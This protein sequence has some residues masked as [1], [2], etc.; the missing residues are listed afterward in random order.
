M[1]ALLWPSRKEVR[2]ERDETPCSPGG[3]N[4]A[5]ASIHD[6][7]SCRGHRFGRLGAPEVGRSSLR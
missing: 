3:L 6:R 5:V 1:L 7:P 4:L 2:A